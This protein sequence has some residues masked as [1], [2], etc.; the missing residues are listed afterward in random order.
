MLQYD[1]QT[2]RRDGTVT[3]LQ[4]AVRLEQMMDDEEGKS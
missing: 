1:E 3:R 2:L 4:A